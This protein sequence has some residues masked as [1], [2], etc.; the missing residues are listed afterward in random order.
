MEHPL[1][2][3]ARLLAALD[4]GPAFPA[5]ND[6]AT[7]LLIALGYAQRVNDG[8]IAIAN[9][10]TANRQALLHLGARFSEVV[11]LPSPYAP[12]AFVMGAKSVD[13]R[14]PNFSGRGLTLAP[15][16]E[17][18]MGEAAEYLSFLRRPLDRRV[19]H[20]RVRGSADGDVR[21][22]ELITGAT[23]WLPACRVLR[24][25]A[26]EVTLSSTGLAAGPTTHAA[27]LGALLEAVERD[28]IARWWYGGEASRRI[29]ADGNTLNLLALLRA[30]VERD[31]W[32]L[33][34]T[35]A[36]GLPVAAALSSEAEGRAV[37]AGF[38]AAPSLARALGSALLEL[39]QMEVAEQLARQRAKTMD[40][41]DLGPFD[42]LWIRRS[43]HLST[44]AFPGLLGD[45][46]APDRASPLP[47]GDPLQEA[48]MRLDH[49]GHRVLV[50]D[51]TCDDVGVPVARALVTG[52]E[53]TWRPHD[54]VGSEDTEIAPI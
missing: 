1:A 39:C 28:A 52:F 43:E 19:V 4:T 31:T 15:A 37:V 7:K 54:L 44:A 9:A 17:S 51:I 25:P 33:D 29:V 53:D 41:A 6:E 38:A 13:R 26:S 16:F 11:R 23:D 8:G 30:S 2:A 10:A 35:P 18:C 3:A 24:E 40:G 47:H 22:I 32:F 5:P 20:R 34:L 42:R 45:P 12:G 46:A 49:H 50:A 21:A 27:R 48:A 14:I 36:H